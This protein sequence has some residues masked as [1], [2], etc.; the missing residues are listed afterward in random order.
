MNFLE[1]FVN[2]VPQEEPQIWNLVIRKPNC[3]LNCHGVEIFSM[4]NRG[5]VECIV[6]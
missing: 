5:F 6:L 4:S 1:V 3:I 2:R